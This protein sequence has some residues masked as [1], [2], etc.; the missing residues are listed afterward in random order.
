MELRQF[1]RLRPGTLSLRFNHGAGPDGHAGSQRR[2]NRDACVAAAR[3]GLHFRT[4]AYGAG[5]DRHRPRDAQAPARR[6][7]RPPVAT[8]LEARNH[9]VDSESGDELVRIDGFS[10]WP[11]GVQTLTRSSSIVQGPSSRT[12]DDG[13]WTMDDPGRGGIS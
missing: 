7:S 11:C 4:D 3:A 2:S 5:L 1:E 9:D 12:M 13:R 6:G 10:G 8:T